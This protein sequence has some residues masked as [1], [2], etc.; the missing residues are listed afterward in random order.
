MIPIDPES[1]II[2]SDRVIARAVEAG[3]EATQTLTEDEQLAAQQWRDNLKPNPSLR[4]T[5]A[6]EYEI[7]Q[8]GDQNFLSVE[9]LRAADHQHPLSTMQALSISASTTLTSA[10]GLAAPDSAPSHR[11]R[12]APHVGA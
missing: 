6:R 1:L 8:T 10:L 4:G 7:A 2:D 3:G 11:R 12:C 5:P 9:A